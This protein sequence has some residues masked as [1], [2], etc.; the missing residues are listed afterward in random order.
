MAVSLARRAPATA[1]DATATSAVAT[2]VLSGPG[3]A[4]VQE[5]IVPEVVAETPTLD[6]LDADQEQP[7]LKFAAKK[8]KSRR[9]RKAPTPKPSTPKPL[10]VHANPGQSAEDKTNYT[11]QAHEGPAFMKG[12]G[13]TN[14]IDQE[15]VNQ[16]YLGDCY[17]CASMAAVAQAQPEAIRNAI[18]DNGDG[19][20]DV[21]LYKSGKPV[22]VKVDNKFPSTAGGKMSYA[23]EG[24]QKDGKTELWPAILEKAW[25]ILNDQ[26][27]NGYEQIEGGL[28]GD[29]VESITGKAPTDYDPASMS[30]KQIVK[31][32]QTALDN[33][34]PVTCATLGE[35]SVTAELKK[36]FDGYGFHA[37]HCY[38]FYSVNVEGETLMLRNPWGME[39]PKELPVAIFKK[40]FDTLAVNKMAK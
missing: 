33:K 34:N 24:D 11:Y 30:G 29:A 36:H 20:F 5:E 40:C 17:W 3:N 21:T 10:A 31:V 18:K 38:S 4:A 9:R 2:P 14:D 8:S 32:I 16:N 1:P 22:V 27:G 26:K 39:H 37:D 25:A 6:L 13:D 23:G 7:S 28:P 19:T 15:D 35:E 12:D